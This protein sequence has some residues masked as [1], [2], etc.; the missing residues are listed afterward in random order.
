MPKP[1]SLIRDRFEIIYRPVDRRDNYVKRCVGLPGDSIEVRN[2]Q[3]FVNGQQETDNGSQQTTYWVTTNGTAI[4]PKAFENM[5]IA[6]S[7]QQMMSGSLYLLP[8][9]KGNAAKLTSFLNVTALTEDIRRS[10]QY[11]PQMFPHNQRYNW[12]EDNYGP[13]WIPKKGATVNIDTSNYH[14]YERLIDVY[15]DND[16]AVRDGKI[17]INGSETST[18][19]F[20]MDY[21]W[22]M[23][24]NRHYSADSRFW[25]FVPED[26]VV[27]KPVFIWLSLDKESKGLGKIRFSRFF[28]LAR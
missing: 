17:F 23:G 9:T 16:F 13:I 28:K 25:G 10:G 21:Y 27:G 8:L 11:E 12:N 14:L 26:H 15:E 4:N 18:Y 24:D 1:I 6:R 20:A 7:D 22:M 2:G 3:L 19:T 5:G